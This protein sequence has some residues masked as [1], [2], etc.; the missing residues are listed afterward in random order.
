MFQA[1]IKEVREALNAALKM[2]E[3]ICSHIQNFVPKVSWI[4]GI[5]VLQ[6]SRLDF[7]LCLYVHR[8]ISFPRF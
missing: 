5:F 1:D 6:I 4:E 7:S 2:T 3:S 8:Q